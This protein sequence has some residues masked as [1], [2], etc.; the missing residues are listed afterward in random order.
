MSSESQETSGPGTPQ[1]RLRRERVQ[2]AVADYL[3]RHET[4]DGD[5]EAYCGSFPEELQEDLREHL[6]CLHDALPMLGER[7][8]LTPDPPRRS[9][10]E[11]RVIR[12]LGRG[13]MGIVYSAIHEPTGRIVAVKVI[14]GD[15]CSPQARLRFR[16]EREAVAR[17]DHPAIVRMQDSGSAGGDEYLVMELVEGTS[18]ADRLERWRAARTGGEAL[19]AWRDRVEIVL[20]IAEALGHAHSRRV[21]HRDIKP[22][23]IL[24]SQE[25]A[26]FLT[27]FGLARAEGEDTITMPGD[28][29]GTVPYMSPEQALARRAPIDH[30][31]DIYSLGVVLYELLTLRRPF[32]GDEESLIYDISF[33]D[34][35]PPRRIDRDV[36]V[37]LQRIC[38]RAMAKNP[39]HRYQTVDA[40]VERL[41][42]VVSGRG[43][44]WGDA[45]RVAVEPVFNFC[46]RH[47]G[48]MASTAA[49]LLLV[50]IPLLVLAVLDSPAPARLTIAGSEPGT[51]VWRRAWN[52]VDDTFGERET[53][54]PVPLDGAEL[55]ARPCRLILVKSDGR[56]VEIPLHDPRSDREYVIELTDV[57]VDVTEGMV[58]V[59][60]GVVSL[61]RFV[62]SGV[63]PLSVETQVADFYIDRTEVSNG[64]YRAFLA[65]LAARGVDLTFLRPD[66][67]PA[68][69]SSAWRDRPD[70]FDRLPVTGISQVSATR[71]AQWRGKRLPTV[72][73]W[74]LAAGGPDGTGYPWGSEPD[75]E[76]RRDGVPVTIP[77]EQL[78]AVGL[79]RPEDHDDGWRDYLRLARPV[80]W[81]PAVPEFQPTILNMLGNVAEMTATMALRDD[82]GR[83]AIDWNSFTARGFFWGC[84]R[85]SI[86]PQGGALG[87]STPDSHPPVDG[88]ANVV[89]FRCARS[90]AP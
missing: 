12:E 29:A 40:L 44:P 64:E 51:V 17:L 7:G 26:V 21:I 47:P 13:G 66:F 30:R 37:A 89:G 23:N 54:G 49:L 83:P 1:E 65:D 71:F 28:I 84:K 46:R 53:V 86:V 63:P 74:N 69:D 75:L 43:V 24:L 81:A 80:D 57:P 18:L 85:S 6:E 58:R 15:R 2:Q 59:T 33:T 45:A 4:G 27:D 67:W 87:W 52:P 79:T 68:E 10:G 60:G 20:R 5:I 31:T 90:V 14:R 55:P 62:A 38:L 77:L 72:A 22:S 88:D 36:P 70:D 35:T 73:E 25:G 50:V 34:P 56:F 82:H 78:A 11:Y 39:A 41:T 9:V 19:P 61:E 76:V 3:S 32:D 42:A 16:R 48:W 8:P